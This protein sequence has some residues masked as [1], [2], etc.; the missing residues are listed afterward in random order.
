VKL[1]SGTASWTVVG[2][3]LCCLAGVAAFMVLGPI[4][5]MMAALPPALPRALL[6]M[7][8]AEPPPALGCT[9]CGYNLAGLPPGSPL[10]RMRL[11]LDDLARPA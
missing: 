1:R 4:G 5:R 3:C 2:I 11:E 7:E 8:D 9:F 6:W 10:P